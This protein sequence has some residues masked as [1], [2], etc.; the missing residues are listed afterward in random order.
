MGAAVIQIL[1]D[2]KAE[3]V[4][5]ATDDQE[6][7]DNLYVKGIRVDE[8]GLRA[9]GWMKQSSTGRLWWMAYPPGAAAD[10]AEEMLDCAKP[11]FFT[12]DE[13]RAIEAAI[14]GARS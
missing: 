12:A 14:E 5:R 11:D 13:I 3:T 7:P 4:R 9:C 8:A 2:S 6:A 1:F 10:L